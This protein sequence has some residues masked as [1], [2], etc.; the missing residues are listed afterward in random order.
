[1]QKKII[2]G[3][4]KMN[5]T[6]LKESEKFFKDLSKNLATIKKTEIVVCPPFLYI[7]K[8]KKVS[9]K[10]VLGAQNVFWGENGAFT[11]EVSAVMLDNVGVK[12]V[13]LGHS[14]QRTLGENNININKK[15]KSVLN[16][17][18]IPV[19]CVGENVRDEDH[20]Y[21]NIVKTQLLECLAGLKK[22]SISKIII[23]YEPVWALSSTI[24]RKD[25]NSADSLEM[26]IFIRKIISLDFGVDSSKIKI[27]YG[28]SVN[29]K[30]GE[31]FL[32]NG[33]VD[34]LLVGKSSLDVKKFF[35]IIKICETL[36]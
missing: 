26:V 16:A 4:W 13:I 22:D 11:G 5:P 6:T 36:N 1:M 7:E 8:L 23:A 14:E 29:E 19:L 12:Y 35:G 31:D 17:G 34:G 28:G 24:D 21:F 27:L 18:L 3:N 30:N 20:G 10:I 2:V 32:R 15:I 33:G 9:R 25:A